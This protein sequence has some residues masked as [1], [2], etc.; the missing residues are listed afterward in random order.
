M[1]AREACEKKKKRV[2]LSSWVL[3]VS[4]EE[5]RKHKESRREV[6]A[7]WKYLGCERPK[8]EEPDFELMFWIKR[9]VPRQSLKEGKTM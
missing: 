9:E 5:A 6:G 4:K 3:E 7:D 2:L 1:K 8:E